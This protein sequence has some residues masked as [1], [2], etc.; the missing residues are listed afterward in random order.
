MVITAES[1][2]TRF[3]CCNV[4]AFWSSSHKG[5]LCRWASCFVKALFSSTSMSYFVLGATGKLVCS[6]NTHTNKLPCAHIKE[7]KT[8]LERLWIRSEIWWKSWWSSFL[9]SPR[10]GQPPE[11]GPY[12]AEDLQPFHHR[13]LPAPGE[14]QWSNRGSTPE[15]MGNQARNSQNKYQDT[16]HLPKSCEE[17]AEKSEDRYI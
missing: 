14:A 8:N 1:E 12:S 9:L 3:C 17:M 2:C 7:K 6:E 16:E 10:H 5:E 11:Q 15:L 13:K 4:L